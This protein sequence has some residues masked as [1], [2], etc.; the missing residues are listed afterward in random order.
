MIVSLNYQRLY[1]F[2]RSWQLDMNYAAPFTGPAFWDYEQ[3]GA[4][5][6]L[7]LAWCVQIVP[8]FSAGLTLNVWNDFLASHSWKQDYRVGA[9]IR[10]GGF[11]GRRTGGKQETY[12]F[13]R[14]VLNVREAGSRLRLGVSAFERQAVGAA[15]DYSHGLEDLL[16]SAITQRNR[17]RAVDR[18][19]LKELLEELKLSQSG[20]VDERKAL[21]VG[22][23]QAADGM[24]FG[25]VLERVD[26][27]EVYVRLVDTE[28]SQIL[29][30][31]DVYG[32][33]VDVEKLRKLARGLDLKLTEALPLVEGV[34]VQAD[35]NRII[36]DMGRHTRITDGMKL[37]VYDIGEPV[38]NP[39]TGRVIGLDVRELGQARIHSVME[40]MSFADLIGDA[41]R[42]AIRP[43]QGVI[44]R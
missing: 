43:A 11:A 10:V 14:D 33:N 24:L 35:G 42:K 20:L 7:G 34:V 19:I 25:S 15:R 28:T 37:I 9:N 1:D 41:N 5:Y 21:E 44:T 27:V 26:S 6:A 13:L 22:R 38:I 16:T 40:H 31:V 18:R 39:L 8:S 4:L 29:A 32:E 12:S 17:F 2:N 30:A 36:V 23:I 3:T